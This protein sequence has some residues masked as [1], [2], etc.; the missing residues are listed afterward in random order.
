M[1]HLRR[2]TRGFVKVSF[3]FGRD[4]KR[5]PENGSVWFSRFCPQATAVCLDNGAADRESHSDSILFCR[6]ERIEDGI[7]M[8]RIPAVTGIHHLDQHAV[9]IS[10]RLNAQ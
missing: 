4:G 10:G 2:Q 7:R 5:K 6:K 9:W 3:R 1:D 8:L